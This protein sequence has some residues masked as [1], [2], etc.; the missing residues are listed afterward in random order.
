MKKSSIHIVPIALLFISTTLVYCKKEDE[1]EK[2]RFIMT[3]NTWYRF[4]PTPPAVVNANGTNY[5]SF[6]YVP[7]GGTGTATDMGNITT[8]FNQLAYTSDATVPQPI[9]LGSLDAS[10]SIVTTLP[11]PGGPLP[12]V[13]VNDFAGMTTANSWLQVPAKDASGK[14]INAV[15]FNASGDAIFTSP[16]SPSI[17]TPVSATRLNFA[18]KLAVAGGRGAFA[19]ATGEMDFTGFFNPQNPNDAGYSFEGWIQY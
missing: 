4:A 6:A 14:V 18:G 5:T 17:V 1:K 7:G 2:K 19:N 13:Q 11:V 9:P 15:V 10:V 3:S 12:L 16:T 8:Y